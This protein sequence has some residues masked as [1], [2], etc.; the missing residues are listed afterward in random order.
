MREFDSLARLP[1]FLFGG[2]LLAVGFVAVA[3]E[4]QGIRPRDTWRAIAAALSQS[5]SVP[6]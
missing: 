6:A 5:G 1:I 3:A 4:A 2:A